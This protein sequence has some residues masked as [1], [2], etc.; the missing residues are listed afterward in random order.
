M[1]T[2]HERKVAAFE[3]SP[4]SFRQ[5]IQLLFLYPPPTRAVRRWSRGEY[6]VKRNEREGKVVTQENEGDL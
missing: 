4:K 6:C 2:D 5:I 1:T 3:R